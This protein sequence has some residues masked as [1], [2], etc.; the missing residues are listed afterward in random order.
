MGKSN[1][2]AYGIENVFIGERVASGGHANLGVSNVGIGRQSLY[3][4]NGGQYN[5]CIGHTA[6]YNLNSGDDNVYIGRAAGYG[7]T[8]SNAIKEL[9]IQW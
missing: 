1:G 6:G 2:V 5:T 8:Q 7:W 9:M 3:L 4:L